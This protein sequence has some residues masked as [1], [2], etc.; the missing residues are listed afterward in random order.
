M[1]LMKLG[2]ENS[3]A[4]VGRMLLLPHDLPIIFTVLAVIWFMG[5]LSNSVIGITRVSHDGAIVLPFTT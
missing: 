4:N 3:C 5:V 1:P 2:H